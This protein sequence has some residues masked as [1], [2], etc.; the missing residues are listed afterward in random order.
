MLLSNQIDYS[1]VKWQG[2]PVFKLASSVRGAIMLSK[3]ANLRYITRGFFLLCAFSLLLYWT[4]QRK[5]LLKYSRRSLLQYDLNSSLSYASINPE[6]T[7]KAILV[8]LHIQKTGGTFV[9]RSLTKSGVFGLPC[10]CTP[11]KKRCKCFIDHRLWIFS[12]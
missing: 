9:E 6:H 5:A 1:K 10:R 8:F 11:D 12:R 7:E 2:P 3:I 4:F